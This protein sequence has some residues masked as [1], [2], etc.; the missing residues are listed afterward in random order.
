MP[1]AGAASRGVTR[2]SPRSTKCVMRGNTPCTAR[3]VTRRASRIPS[4]PALHEV[5]IWYAVKPKSVNGRTAARTR[6]APPIPANVLRASC[7][8][9]NMSDNAKRTRAIAKRLGLC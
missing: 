7:K 3:R 1:S 5:G 4:L 6:R 8:S 2:R 9:T